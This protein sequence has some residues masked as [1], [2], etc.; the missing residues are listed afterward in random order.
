MAD[1]NMYCMFMRVGFM[2]NATLK[3]STRRE[4]ERDTGGGRKVCV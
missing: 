1:I 4:R 2:Y 3:V